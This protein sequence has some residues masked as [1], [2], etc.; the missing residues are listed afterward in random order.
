MTD[1]CPKCRQITNTFTLTKDNGKELIRNTT[2]GG[3]GFEITTIE[4]EPKKVYT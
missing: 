4:K 2:C 1:G 3:C